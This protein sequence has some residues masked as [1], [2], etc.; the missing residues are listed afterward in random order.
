[1]SESCFIDQR[2]NVKVADYEHHKLESEN[3]AKRTS[4]VSQVSPITDEDEENSYIEDP[5]IQVTDRIISNI[6]GK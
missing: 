2:W 4:Q 6:M 3:R 1:M 5:N